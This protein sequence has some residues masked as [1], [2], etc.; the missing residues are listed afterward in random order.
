MFQCRWRP[1]ASQHAI[2]VCL[3]R[4]LSP[5]GSTPGYAIRAGM[6]RCPVSVPSITR[7]A[8]PALLKL[9]CCSSGSVTRDAGTRRSAWLSRVQARLLADGSRY[10]GDA[11]IAVA[12]AAIPDVDADLALR[13]TRRE[14]VAALRDVGADA[15]PS[16]HT[17]F[18]LLQPMPLQTA[19]RP[20]KQGCSLD[21]VPHGIRA[22]GTML[23]SVSLGHVP[24]LQVSAAGSWQLYSSGQQCVPTRWPGI[25]AGAL[26][27]LASLGFSVA[28]VAGSGTAATECRVRLR[29][30]AALAVA[31]PAALQS[32]AAFP[33]APAA[34]PALPTAPSCS[35]LFRGA[36]EGGEGG[37]S[38]RAEDAQHAT[39]LNQA[40]HEPVEAISV[41]GMTPS[42]NGTN[43]GG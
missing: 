38:G 20:Q 41:H 40:L 7:D 19:A 4:V 1:P 18:P 16:K 23:H 3:K 28:G 5:Q 11:E 25:W 14:V 37:E 22:C 36:A 31:A 43:R 21:S 35:G 29:I 42:L 26:S 8:R 34:G 33:S 2:I 30:T 17:A 24:A 9:P 32:T 6:A 39:P 15:P 12:A 13:T 10:R 27:C